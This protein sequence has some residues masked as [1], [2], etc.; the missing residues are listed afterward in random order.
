MTSPYGSN[1]D[2]DLA[3]KS[4]SEVEITDDQTRESF[5]S[6]IVKSLD[7]FSDVKLTRTLILWIDSQFHWDWLILTIDSNRFWSLMVQ[8]QLSRIKEQLLSEFV[9]DDMCPRG[10]QLLEDTSHEAYEVILEL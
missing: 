1:E 6:E 10:N 8:Y 4:L 3:S 2:D 7:T 5:V 9:P